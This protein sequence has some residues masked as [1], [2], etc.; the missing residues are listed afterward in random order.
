M[1]RERIHTRQR[2]RDRDR[3]RKE[4]ERKRTEI[5]LMMLHDSQLV[6]RITAELCE[7]VPEKAT[8]KHIHRLQPPLSLSY[9]TVE[10]ALNVF[11]LFNQSQDCSVWSK[12]S[13]SPPFLPRALTSL[14]R[15]FMQRPPPH[16]HTPQT[17]S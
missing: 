10:P 15:P 16:T 9:V 14:R 13:C 4:R 6:H 3:E 17:H 2:Q 11:S 7:Q 8:E 5:N 12:D 1:Y